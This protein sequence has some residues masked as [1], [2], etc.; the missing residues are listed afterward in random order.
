M[1][2]ILGGLCSNGT[3]TAIRPESLH[4]ARFFTMSS[5]SACDYLCESVL[6]LTVEGLFSEAIAVFVP[7]L[8]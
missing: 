8:V 1:T 5:Q 3:K 7:L 2:A 6:P 4:S